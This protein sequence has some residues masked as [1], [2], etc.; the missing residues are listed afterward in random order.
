[1]IDIYLYI[2]FINKYYILYSLIITIIKVYSDFF[3]EMTDTESDIKEILEPNPERTFSQTNYLVI[4]C[5]PGVT[6]PN[7]VLSS[8]LLNTGLNADDFKNTLRYFGEWTYNLYD[9]KIKLFKENFV[10]IVERLKQRY[11]SGIIRYAEYNIED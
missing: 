9:D 7:D 5:P 4:D 8:I 1:M 3:F 2:I 10:I 11:N 6:R